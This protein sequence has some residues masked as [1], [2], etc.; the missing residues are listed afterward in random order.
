ML[1]DCVLVT[2]DK[3]QYRAGVALV[4]ADE[5][6]LGRGE[7]GAAESTKRELRFCLVADVPEMAT[8]AIEGT[9]GDL[10]ELRYGFIK[11]GYAWAFPKRD[12][13]SFG[14]GGAV[15]HARALRGGLR[16]VPPAARH[17]RRGAGQGLL[18][19]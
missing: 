11:Q 17:Q 16:P 15:D 14:I 2:T 9:Y 8:E 7:V 4:G 13:I 5:R 18:Y 6:L 1:A 19:P 3:A 12:H 10:V